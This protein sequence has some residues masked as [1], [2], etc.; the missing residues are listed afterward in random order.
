MKGLG[1]G[2]MDAYRDPQEEDMKYYQH[3]LYGISSSSLLFFHWINLLKSEDKGRQ[4]VQT[5]PGRGEARYLL[6][7]N[8]R[9]DT[10]QI[11]GCLQE[12]SE[13]EESVPLS[14]LSN[15]GLI[16]MLARE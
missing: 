11:L 3:F 8:K 7:T 1:H 12:L 6:K 10:H 14:S 13:F 4:A 16:W 9:T 15:P 2:N 5:E